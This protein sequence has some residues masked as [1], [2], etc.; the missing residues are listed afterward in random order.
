MQMIGLIRLGRDA[1][2][3]Q[4]PAGMAVLEF[5]GV[6]DVQVKREKAPQWV[7]FSMFG[8]R[9]EAVATYMT[10]GKQ[11][12]VSASAP[13]VEVFQKRD[14]TSGVKLVA[15]A[16]NIEFAG[17]AQDARRDAQPS[18]DTPGQERQ[19]QP[20]RSAQVA[21]SDDSRDDPFGTMDDDIP[22]N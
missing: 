14:G 1:E 12:V 17:S 22:F 20:A 19:Q 16:D 13:R 4:T 10:K 2:L 11:V 9:A 7:E 8:K 3:K 5:S 15:I 6:Y 21:R 18:G